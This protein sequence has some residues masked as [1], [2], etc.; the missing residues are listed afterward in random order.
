MSA[1]SM[2]AG[3]QLDSRSL[4]NPVSALGARFATLRAKLALRSAER[5][6]CEHLAHLDDR[7]LLDIG[8]SETEIA[9]LRAGEVFSPAGRSD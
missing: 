9:R 7:L 6:L 2:S 4:T 5:R 3:A 8:I 1:H